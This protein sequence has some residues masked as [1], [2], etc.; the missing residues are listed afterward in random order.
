MMIPCGVT[1]SAAIF[2]IVQ[3]A[4]AIF[5][6]PAWLVSI[7]ADETLSKDHGSRLPHRADAEHLHISRKVCGDLLDAGAR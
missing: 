1:P 2:I 6:S 7:K 3:D 4:G 5:L